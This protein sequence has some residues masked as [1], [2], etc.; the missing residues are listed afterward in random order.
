M[1]T[2]PIM[3]YWSTPLHRRFNGFA[4]PWEMIAPHDAQAM[5]NHSDQNLEKL[6][7]RGGLSCCE[8]MAV[9]EDRRWTR[10]D[11]DEAKAQLTKLVENY[12]P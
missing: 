8:A 7:S 3:G 10:M 2:F 5:K 11:Q 6:A 4:I 1:K 12:K 9:L